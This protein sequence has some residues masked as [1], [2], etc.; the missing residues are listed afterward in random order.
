LKAEANAIWKDVP[1]DVIELH[2]VERV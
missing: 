1:H 2:I